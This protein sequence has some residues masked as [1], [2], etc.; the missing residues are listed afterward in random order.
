[1]KFE[2]MRELLGLQQYGSF[3]LTSE[4]VMMSRNHRLAG[5]E[6]VL[7]SE[8]ENETLI[9]LRDD[10][11]LTETVL[12]ALNQAGFIPSKT[13]QTEHTDTVPGKILQS[14]GV[15]ITGSG[16]SF[17]GYE[18]EIIALPI[19]DPELFFIK[20]YAWNKENDNPLIRCFLNAVED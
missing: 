7:L 20:S 1:M 14:G 9:T 5:K 19:S 8:L 16:Y 6:S 2:Y 11:Y 15:Y 13:A 4:K 10:P 18:D 17:P 12:E 3:T